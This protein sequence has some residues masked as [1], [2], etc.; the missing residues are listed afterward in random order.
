MSQNNA[1]VHEEARIIIAGAWANKYNVHI[2]LLFPEVFHTDCTCDT[3]NT[4]NYL[5]TFS[6]RISTGKQVGFLRVWIPN[7]KRFTFRWVFK[8]VLNSLFEASA[9]CRTRLVMVDS[10]PQ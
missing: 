8:V 2:F 3:N 9:Y 7:Q 10:D 1:R 4:N 5:L 6:C